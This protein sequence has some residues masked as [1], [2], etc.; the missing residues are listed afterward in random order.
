MARIAVGG[1]HHETNTFSP[2][3]HK[4]DLDD[5]LKGGAYP[6]LCRGPALFDAVAGMNL[7]VSG[8]IDEARAR[9]H[10]VVPL[11]WCFATPSAHTT[12]RAFETIAGWLLDDLAAAGPVDAL[13]L[14]LHGAMVT[15]HLEDGDGEMLRRGRAAVGDKVPVVSALD[16]HA[17]ITPAMM[18]NATALHAMRTYPHVDRAETGRR[19]ARHVHGLLQGGV[20][21]KAWRKIPFLISAPCQ[22]TLAEPTRSIMAIL[23]DLEGGDVEA[24]N[25]TPGFPS[26][27]VY[28][29]G[30]TVFG[31]GRNRAA[32]EAAVAALAEE[33]EGREA[34]FADAWVSAEEGVRHAMRAKAGAIGPVILADTQDNPGGGGTSDTTGLLKTLVEQGARDAVLAM[35][36]DDNAARRAHEAGEGAEIELALGGRSGIPGD[37]PF[38]A[39][40]TVDRLGDG[41]FEAHGAMMAGITYRLGPMALLRTGGVRVVVS[42]TKAQALD[43][44]IL[45]HLGVDPSAQKIIALKSSVHFRADFAEIASDIVVVLAPGSVIA[46]TRLK[47]YRKLRPGVRLAPLGPVFG[48]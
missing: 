46:D 2:A 14:D 4:A 13:Y 37:A 16:F 33:V 1:I 20:P 6:A 45:R 28:H 32:V 19:A 9:G 10:E 21:F 41:T 34:E 15:E 44:G 18:E 35:M 25:F 24:L 39:R 3:S 8:F 40:F 12:E 30:P 26:A 5:Y 7:T 29:L 38:R 48:A 27:D 23:K 22:C 17:I 42:G 31:Y 47:D 36:Y 11:L 43:Q